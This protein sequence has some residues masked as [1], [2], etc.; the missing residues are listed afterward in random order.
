M[1]SAEAHTIYRQLFVMYKTYMYRLH[2]VINVNIQKSILGY[3]KLVM[4]LKACLL[5]NINIHCIGAPNV[6]YI[7]R[8]SCK[9]II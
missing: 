7:Y 1:T 2:A 8:V 5:F 4:S 3:S 6:D 9:S